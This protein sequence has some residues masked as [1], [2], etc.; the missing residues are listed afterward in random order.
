LGE[1]GG[2]MDIVLVIFAGLFALSR[3]EGEKERILKVLLGNLYNL[4]RKKAS[5]KKPATAKELEHVEEIEEEIIEESQ[6]GLLLQKHML[7]IGVLNDI[8]F[9]D[10]H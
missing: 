10:F 2:F 6:D 5:D 1:L 3:V 7:Q 4:E 9:Q 8:I